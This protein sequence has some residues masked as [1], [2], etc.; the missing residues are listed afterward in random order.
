MPLLAWLMTL[1]PHSAK[2]QVN[3]YLKVVGSATI[4]IKVTGTVSEFPDLWYSTD[5]SNWT[6]ITGATNWNTGNVTTYFKGH[7]PGGFNHSST[8]FVSIAI[9]GGNPSLAGNV[10]SLIDDVNFA[11]NYSTIP[12]DYCFYALFSPVPP[13]SFNTSYSTSSSTSSSLQKAHEL[14]L[15]ATNLRAYCYAYMFAQNSGLFNAPALP[16]TVMQPWCYAHMFEYCINNF[17]GSTAANSGWYFSSMT[18]P[19][20]QLAEGCYAFMFNCCGSIYNN[21]ANNYYILPAEE[22]A[23]KCYMG[24]FG[25][26]GGISGGTSLRYLEIM[27]TSLKDRRGDDITN[28]MAYMFNNAVW[29]GTSN[30]RQNLTIR[31]YWTDWGNSTTGP[32]NAGATSTAPT[33]CWFYGNVRSGNWFEYQNGLNLTSKMTSNSTSTYNH[34]FPYNSTPTGSNYTYLTFDCKTNGGTWE[35]DDDYNV[36]MRRV[37]RAGYTAKTVPAAPH[38]LG[39]TFLGWFTAPDGGTQVSEATIKTQTTAQTYYAHFMPNDVDFTVTIANGAHGHVVVSRNNAPTA[40]YTSTSS[41][42]NMSELTITAVPDAGYRFKAWTGDAATIKTA[43]DNGTTYYLVNDITVGATFEADECTVTIQTPAEYG[44]LAASDGVN[45]YASGNTYTFNRQLDLNKVLTFTATPA[46]HR[47]FTGFT[48]TE[49]SNVTAAPYV[50]DQTVTGTYTI[51]ALTPDE[52]TVGATFV[53]PQYT[54]TG[55][56]TGRGNGSVVLTADGYPEQTG[57]GTYDIDA[58]VTLTATPANA[59][60]KFV[61]WTDNDSD[62]PVR[63]YTVLGDATFE[64]E[65]DLDGDLWSAPATVDVYSSGVTRTCAS[66]ITTSNYRILYNLDPVVG[67]DGITYTPVDM[68]AGVAWADK[69]IGATDPTKA[70]SYFYWGGTTAYGKEGYT[71]VSNSNYYKEVADMTATTST[72][73]AAQYP[74]PA[75]ADAATKRMG[76]QWRMPTYYEMNNLISSTYTSSAQVNYNYTVTNK[77]YTDDKIFIPAGGRY[78]T[79][80]SKGAAYLWTSTVA[81][82]N[83]ASSKPYVYYNHAIRGNTT[84]TGYALAYYAMPVR[85][86]YVPSFETCTLKVLVYW[87]STLKWTYNYICEVGQTVTIRQHPAANGYKLSAWREN[88]YSGTELSTDNSYTVTLTGNQTIAAHYISAT[89]YLLTTKAS[90]LKGGTVDGGGYYPTGTSVTLTAAPNAN[91]RFVRWSDGNTDNPRTYTTTNA[92]VTLTAE[93]EGYV[94][95]VTSPTANEEVFAYT[96]NTN[97]YKIL[98]DLPSEVNGYR[99]VDMGNGVAWANKNLG[100]ADSTASGNYYVWGTTS[101]F[102]SV[103][104][105]TYYAGAMDIPLTTSTTLSAQYALPADSD[106]A[107]VNMG[108]RWRMPNYAEIYYLANPNGATEAGAASTGFTYTNKLSGE[109]LFIP[110]AGCYKS[111]TSKTACTIFWGS[112]V[113]SFNANGCNC[114]ASHYYNG[115]ANYYY[116]TSYPNSYVYYALP[117]RAVY[118]PPFETCTLKVTVTGLKVDGSGTSTHYYY[119]I[120][121]VGQRVRITAQPH[122]VGSTGFTY[123]FTQWTDDDNSSAV[124]GTDPTID[125]VIAGNTNYTAT[126][127]STTSNFSTIHALPQP[128]SAG[129]VYGTGRYKN[130]VTTKLHAVP[131]EGWTFVRWED[132]NSTD[133]YREITV[134]GHATYNAVFTRAGEAAAS[135][136]KYVNVWHEATTTTTETLYDGSPLE[137]CTLTVKTYQSNTAKATY[138]YVCEKGQTVTVSAFTNTANYSLLHWTNA[139]YDIMSYDPTVELVVTGNMTY[140]ATFYTTR[141]TT[142]TLTLV[143]SPLEGAIFDGAVKTTQLGVYEDGQVTKLICHPKPHYRFL[144]WDDDHSQT[145]TIRY[146]TV[147]ADRTYTAV[148]EM[149][150]DLTT[151]HSDD[152]FAQV[153]YGGTYQGTY[154]RYDLPGYDANGYRPV[155]VGVGVAWANKNIGAADSTKAGDYFVWGLTTPATTVN[156]NGSAGTYYAG[157]TS[158]TTT[159]GYSTVPQNTLPAE[160]DAATQIMGER[161]RMP[162]CTEIYNLQGVIGSGSTEEGQ[163]SAGFRYTNVENTTQHIYIPAAGSKST[164]GSSNV[165][166]NVTM[167]WG[168]TVGT[169]SSQSSRPSY[170]KDGSY[171]AGSTSYYAWHALPVRAVYVPPF[172][173]CSVKVVTNSKTYIYMCEVGQRITITA[174]YGAATATNQSSR[175]DKWV[176][177]DNV[178]V[179]T[180]Q[181]YSFIAL[182]DVTLTVTYTSSYTTKRTLTFNVSPASSGTV[183]NL[184]SFVGQYNDGAKVRIPVKAAQ[185][186][187]FAYWDDDHSNTDPDRIFT[188]TAN[189][190]YTAVFEPDPAQAVDARIAQAANADTTKILYPL[191][192]LYKNSMF[193]TPVDMGTGTAWC[194]YNVGVTA[195][196]TLT[197]YY[198][199]WGKNGSI[200]KYSNYNSTTFYCANLSSMSAEDDLPAN[201]TYDIA[202]NQLGT[203]WRVPSKQQWQDLIDNADYSDGTFTSKTDATKQITLPAAGVK[204]PTATN[205]SG[206]NPSASNTTHR[207]YWSSTLQS[208]AGTLWQSLPYCFY[209]GEVKYGTNVPANG[210]C[211]YGMPVR[212]V[213][214]P[215]F[216]PDT[217]RVRYTNGESVTRTNTYLVQRGQPVKVTAI[218]DDGYIF[219][220]WSDDN[221]DATR[222]FFVTGNVTL[223]AEFAKKSENPIINF[224]SEDGLTKITWMEVEK[225]T[226][227]VYDGEEPTKES[228]AEFDYPFAGWTDANDNFYAKNTSLPAAT[229]DMDYFATFTPV[230]RSYTVTFLNWDG[231]TLQ[232]TDVEYGQT[233]SYSGTP[234]RPADAQYTYTFNGWDNEVVAVTGIATYTATYSNTLNS[235]TVTFKDAAG[236]TIQSG[237]LDYGV[238]PTFTGDIPVKESADPDYVW[239]FTGW[240]DGNDSFTAKGTALPAVGGTTVYTATYVYDLNYL[241]IT[242]TS[243]KAGYVYLDRRS[244]GGYS[245]NNLNVAYSINGGAWTDEITYGTSAHDGLS[246]S[247]PAGQSIRF[248]GYNLINGAWQCGK[249]SSIYFGFNFPT[250]GTTFTVSG[251]LMTLVAYQNGEL[252]TSEHP[253]GAY[254]FRQLFKDCNKLTD[255]S[256]LKLSATTLSNYCYQAMFS[257]CTALTSAPQISATSL[258]Q[259][260]YASMFSGCTSLTAGPA[261]PAM[262]LANNCYQYMFSGCTHLTAAPQLP[263]TTL[264]EGCYQYMFQGC[265]MLTGV[266]EALPGTNL[267]ANCYAYMFSGC[268]ALTTAPEIMAAADAV[269]GM[270][271]CDNMFASCTSLTKAPSRLLPTTVTNNLTYGHMFYNCTSLTEGPD[272]FVTNINGN[273]SNTKM[274]YM[275]SS[276][277]A[278]TKIRAYFTA[279][280]EMSFCSNWTGSINT[281]G[282]FYCPPELERRYNGSES[283]PSFIPTNWTV[284]SYDITLIPVGGKWADNTSAEK[285]FT[286]RTDKSDIDDFIA[287]QVDGDNNSL[288]QGWYLNP[289]CTEA[290]TEEAVKAD[291]S[292]QQTAETKRIYVR[293]N[294]TNPTL[295]WDFNGGNTTSTE[296]EYTFG[297]MEVGDPITAPANP[298]RFGYTFMGWSS[299]Q[300][301]DNTPVTVATTMPATDLIYTAIWQELPT[302]L[303]TANTGIMGAATLTADHYDD[304]E[305]SGSYIEGT[306][307]TISVTPYFG[308]TFTGWSDSNTQNPRT[309]TV[310]STAATYTAQFSAMDEIDIT[311]TEGTLDFPTYAKNSFAI[312]GENGQVEVRL[313]FGAAISTGNHLANLSTDL[314]NSYI[315]PAGESKRQIASA[316]VATVTYAGE[317]FRAA[318][319]VAKVTDTQGRKY[320]IDIYTNYCINYATFQEDYRYNSN[321]NAGYTESSWMSGR[322]FEYGENNHI[323]YIGI[324]SLVHTNVLRFFTMTSSPYDVCHIWLQF[325]PLTTGEGK[326]PTGVYPIN[327]TGLPGTVYVGSIPQ[328]YQYQTER[329]TSTPAYYTNTGSWIYHDFTS[330]QYEIRYTDNWTLRGGYVEVVNVDETY[331]VHVHAYTDGYKTLGEQPNTVIDFT[332]GGATASSLTPVGITIDARTT[333]GE[334]LTDAVTATLSGASNWTDVAIGQG[335]HTFFSGNTLDLTA[336]KPGY[337]FDHWEVNGSPVAGEDFTYSYTVGASEANIVAVFAVDNRPHYTLTTETGGR[338]TVT[339]TAAGYLAQTGS[340]YYAENT[341]VTMSVTANTGSAFLRWSDGNTQNPRTVTVTGDITYTAEFSLESADAAVSVYQ[342]VAA[343]STKIL[344]NLDPRTGD[345][346]L[347]YIPVDMGYG[348]AWADRNVGA[349]G[350]NVIGSYFRWGDPVASNTFNSSIHIDASGFSTGD[351]LSNEQD[352][353]YVNMGTCWH[354]PDKNELLALK[355]NTDLS[356]NNTFTNKTDNTKS[357]VFLAGGYKGNSHYDPDYQYYWS[358]EY[359]MYGYNSKSKSNERTCFAFVRCTDNVYYASNY[360]KDDY[361]GNEYYLGMPVRAIY[362]PVYPTYTL[363]INVG[364]KAYQYI[365]QAGQ[366][367]TVTAVPDEGYAFSEWTDNHNTTAVR[368]FTMTGN[369]TTTA[370]FVLGTQYYD[371]TVAS[372]NTDYGTVD[373]TAINDVESGTGITVS[374]ST[375]TIGSTTVT[376]TKTT[377][378]AQYTYTFSGWTDTEGNALP[379]TV[380]GDLNIRA[381]FTRTTNSYAVRFLNG[382]EVLQNTNVEYGQ[383]PAYTGEQPVKAQTDEY[384][385]AFSGWDPAIT[386]VTGAQDYTATFSSTPRSYTLTWDFAGGATATAEEDYTHGTVEYGTTIT[387]P[388]DPTKTGYTFN[389][390]TPDVAET[391]PAANTAYTAQWTLSETTYDVTIESGN[392]GYGTVSVAAINDVEEGTAI[393]VSGNTLTVG[394]TTV[395]ATATAGS[396]GYSYAFSSWTDGEGN[397]L[398]ETVTE[399]LTVR[400]NFTRE[401]NLVL[402]EHA[403]DGDE[404]YDDFAA[405]YNGET[406]KT[407]TLNRQFTQSRWATLC[408]PFEVSSGLMTNLNMKGR[409]YEFKHATGT[410]TE[411]DKVTLYFAQAASLTAGKCYIVNAN[412]KL[413]GRTEF[414]FPNVTINTDSDKVAPLNSVGQYNQLSGYSDGEGTIQL[415]GTLRLGT[416]KGTESGNT[417]MGLKENKIYYPNIESGSTVWA[418]RGVFRSTTPLGAQRIRIVVEGEEGE[419]VTE[420]EVVNGELQQAGET[421]KFVQDGILY[422]EHDGVLYDATGRRVN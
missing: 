115:G 144:Y 106:A 107:T 48:G 326:I 50:Y 334:A 42:H 167:F 180:D 201:T 252:H 229:E 324:P 49:L 156:S 209:D 195:P 320:N 304:A 270:G 3:E 242:N 345:D 310:G 170:Y 237:T 113:G 368:T 213:Y 410:A 243:N 126:F 141:V 173:T 117:V 414:V 143:S 253:M 259:Y 356:N 16:A 74:L 406:A 203:N 8:N 421:R 198:T 255:A 9:T 314:A 185:N 38:K 145:D 283:T 371:V 132:N 297:V 233:P 62:N 349:T 387:A 112:T 196:S 149:D 337:V 101:P 250:S 363:T 331:Y 272:I 225:N 347:T 26:Y 258:A 76:G 2:A 352:A 370:T 234:T 293:L 131:E 216:T 4:N 351:K 268:S 236:N 232:A 360:D 100:A 134:N 409:V 222:S 153:Y 10:M 295:L 384:T 381:N 386:T 160:A 267:P 420:L 218:P 392:A 152:A 43:E 87:A 20:Q 219:S 278:L 416:L 27:A 284:Y 130:G 138:N 221:V 194:D 342:N 301:A 124:V 41:V 227:P 120:C 228:T 15:P 21:D 391:M 81:A 205:S 65:F 298:T 245:T 5:R 191:P 396:Y 72:T 376:A 96:A 247:L 84:S 263:A 176:N 317:L 251:D 292:V 189:A 415:V 287:A 265:T 223:T 354:M 181:T 215:S 31:M 135:A 174:F 307:V 36:D 66:T 241:T 355:G 286:W 294:G 32:A 302:Y 402:D 7:N 6:P 71:T 102:T 418:Y 328:N 395:T 148:L 33:Y 389:G 83:G 276:A 394:E 403:E 422:I 390:W 282:S 413:A 330:G 269:P 37:V 224:M 404:F 231:S 46:M 230:R 35:A 335:S 69:N 321:Y 319:L 155:D 109:Q 45:A 327:S 333:G 78:A 157:V 199:I 34:T 19:A 58:V 271:A 85:A 114:S 125:F 200:T 70:G 399:D 1:A 175:V 206:G 12:C 238:V 165:T 64:A 193:Y 405:R 150:Y 179:C 104:T 39:C 60:F 164:S 171:S 59:M 44:T 273:S 357:I 23:P 133:P 217:V 254:C 400:A 249:S 99:P 80:L 240:T 419:T 379:A 285:Q 275:F 339:L 73:V 25:L 382:E 146:V 208:K 366:N 266:P 79:S 190:T 279:W 220:K 183:N 94:T 369:I 68:G 411:G 137:T 123:A 211:N 393:T 305:G 103:A 61:K 91:Y 313:H 274:Q 17:Y 417:Y 296:A 163:A 412:A 372:S 239:N 11:T 291:L 13:S 136:H 309:I 24:M 147:N 159:A 373:V 303:I 51:T 210:Y 408:L 82:K 290:T 299:A 105:G 348:V 401:L 397:A 378:D 325:N 300:P 341:N 364:D 343:S 53:K 336:T 202:M 407:V 350:T 361:Y 398:P 365:C 162:N 86:V 244:T 235:Y 18:L 14:V 204:I 119:Y 121:E 55:T 168:S 332:A 367:I 151:V 166:P 182:S 353:A 88:T 177:Q 256:G 207:Y 264:T 29:A 214:V 90:P 262:T 340:G 248:R 322:S 281:T 306:Q 246:I 362:E 129:Y 318:H 142:R 56:K 358:R 192:V 184:A 261:L 388:A 67:D 110:A 260:C 97:C 22:L 161:W 30:G 98:Y 178:T 308:Y 140:Y 52:V 28:C 57:S 329:Q 344:Y 187:R 323:N 311:M 172:E 77:Y 40:T 116:T 374:G 226:V 154:L 316:T 289:A 158:M 377:D 197:G 346:G 89:T 122:S 118:V 95:G 54:V 127:A 111:G 169:I 47:L 128:R 315:Q 280:G 380:T 75:G 92:A 383:T 338:G 63:T 359:A 288:I 212:A 385:Y 93:F 312:I 188:A 277:T 108:E 257:G 186:Y 375:L 139:N